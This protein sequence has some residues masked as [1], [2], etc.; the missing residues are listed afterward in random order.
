MTF[1]EKLEME[2]PD[3]VDERYQ[4]GCYLCPNNYGYE[5]YDSSTK[6]CLK[7]GGKGCSYCWNRE[8][9]EEKDSE[10]MKRDTFSKSDLKDGMVVEYRSGEKALLLGDLFINMSGSCDKDDFSDNLEIV[11]H[12]TEIDYSFDII[13]VYTINRN[14][15]YPGL[16]H[17]LNDKTNQYLDL[18]WERNEQKKDTNNDNAHEECEEKLT[19]EELY[20][21]LDDFCNTHNECT[22][23]PINNTG[24]YC[25]STSKKELKRL[26]KIIKENQSLVEDDWIDTVDIF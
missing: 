5:N 18:I 20:E 14:N 13:K 12:E 16:K 3:R 24:C 8:T 15:Q 21:K 17:I 10:H 2:H 11:I 9:P 25:K 7:K 4:G 26:W 19:Y 1:K 22:E 23:C 6:N